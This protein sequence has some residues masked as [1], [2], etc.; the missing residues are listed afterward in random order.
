[1]LK[2]ILLKSLRDYRWATLWWSLGVALTILL[3]VAIYP[4]YSKAGEE[5]NALLDNPAMKAFIGEMTDLTT[6]EGFFTME[7]FNMFFPILIIIF[8]VMIGT[9]FVSGDE[10]EG[11]LELLISTPINRYSIIAQ[12]AAA[13]SILTMFLGSIFLVSIVLGVIAIDIDISLLNVTIMCLHLILLGLIFGN[14]SFFIGSATGNKGYSVGITCALAL[15]GYL[16]NAF[17][18]MSTILD[19]MK[20]LSPFYYYIDQNPLF[21]GFNL[22]HMIILAL[23]VLVL[24]FLS[25]VLFNRR[26]LT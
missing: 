19:A 6:P 9:N 10:K 17:S 5:L 7:G 8:S 16:I 11:T 23:V 3:L 15:I 4:D 20:Y 18:S 1:M 13:L 25:I 22:L 2:N 21:Y 26:N 24:N 12:K 14:L